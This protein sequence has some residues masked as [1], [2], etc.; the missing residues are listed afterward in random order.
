MSI[1]RLR[2]RAAICS[3]DRSARGMK[4]SNAG[5]TP[6][7]QLVADIRAQ[8]EG[9]ELEARAIMQLEQLRGEGRDRV[10]AKVG[11]E[12]THTDFAVCRMAAQR[13]QLAFGLAFLA[14]P[15]RCDLALQAGRI[16][17]G[18]RRK[19]SHGRSASL[20]GDGERCELGVEAGPIADAHA[21]VLA[22]AG[23]EFRRWSERQRTLIARQ[24]LV[25]PGKLLQRECLIAVGVR[26]IRIQRECALVT[27]QRL[28][29]AA[30]LV[31]RS[32]LVQER[33]RILRFQL[34]RPL[35]SSRAPP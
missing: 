14:R 6:C 12:I 22:D 7:P 24:G 21:R 30:Q 20:Y 2:A 26:I 27:R 18:E 34:E 33:L 13:R 4:R 29:E 1:S 17:Q 5:S 11:G 9:G 28:V 32:A 19:G 3:S 8:G 25:R 10:I 35:R 23:Q 16:E 31:Q 15:A